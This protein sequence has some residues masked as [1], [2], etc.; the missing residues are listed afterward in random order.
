[1]Y[2]FNISILPGSETW[3]IFTVM[4]AMLGSGGLALYYSNSNLRYADFFLVTEII[5]TFVF[6]GLIIF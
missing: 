6:C 1:V 4:G 2:P 3:I 5:L